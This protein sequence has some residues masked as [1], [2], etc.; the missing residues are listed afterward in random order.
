MRKIII[1]LLLITGFVL[2]IKA[3]EK[4][5][6]DIEKSVIKWSGSYSFDF[7]GHEGTVKI[8]DGELTKTNGRISA[9]QFIIDMNTI[10]NTDDYSQDLIDHLK[11]DDFFDVKNHPTAKLVINRVKYHDPNNTK[12]S[13]QIYIRINGDLTIKGIR[14]PVMFEAEIDPGQTNI[15]AKLKIDRTLW[16]VSFKSKSISASIK[17][18]IISDAI[19]FRISLRIN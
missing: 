3:Q 4:V 9:G 14:Q 5:K 12:F 1:A 13:K 7:G 8:K 11:S 15:L 16:N 6:I 18:G 2:H 10:V 17:D 19:E